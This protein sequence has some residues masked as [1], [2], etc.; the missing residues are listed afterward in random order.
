MET[1]IQNN[2]N[3]NLERLVSGL[4]HEDSRNLRM[5]RNFM[6]LMWG[7]APLY[8]LFA[9]IG[10]STEETSAQHIGFV[11]FSLGFLTFGFLFR[12]L[13]A[14]YQSVDYGLPT[15]EMLRRAVKRYQF[16]QT[17]TYLTIIPIILVCF[18]TSFSIEHLLPYPDQMLRMVI[19]FITYFAMLCVAFFI[20]YLVWRRRQKPLR[21]K[22]LAM[23]AEMEG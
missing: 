15:V 8:L 18:A 23:L 22:A 10:F 6:W 19:V 4:Q 20:G 13:K 3:I 12:T 11:F 2:T 16:W 17:K 7:M 21:D 9:V 14:D 5:T 1:I